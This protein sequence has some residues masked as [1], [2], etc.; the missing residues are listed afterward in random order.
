MELGIRRLGHILDGHPNNL[1]AQLR[2][3][4][5]HGR[6][7]QFTGFA[8]SVQDDADGGPTGS[9]DPWMQNDPWSQVPHS[10]RPQ[11]QHQQYHQN[12]GQDMWNNW[13]P[14]QQQSP[15]QPQSPQPQSMPQQTSEPIYTAVEDDGTDSD[16]VSSFQDHLDYNAPDLQNLEASEVDEAI[17]WAYQRAKSRW[18]KH[19]RW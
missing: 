6:G 3:W 15:V 2:N 17:F 1:A 19:M 10:Q 16:T 7:G 4:T 18:R 11:P 5:H 12:G 9:S 8:G 14:G 13:N